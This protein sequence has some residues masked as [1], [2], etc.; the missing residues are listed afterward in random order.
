MSGEKAGAW[1][2]IAGSGAGLVIMALHPTHAGPPDGGHLDMVVVVHAAAI[3][4]APVLAFGAAMLTRHLGFARPLPVLGLIFY[5]FGVASVMLAAAMSGLVVPQIVA[6]GPIDLGDEADRL[7]NFIIYTHWLNQAFA[8]IHVALVSIAIL[9][10]SIAWPRGGVV[11]WFLRGLGLII[12]V[13]ILTWQ[14]SG[15]LHLN[16]LGMGH[17]VAVHGL[18]IVFAAVL[19]LRA[20]PKQA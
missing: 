10:W 19:M 15:H 20:Q 3:G 4:A 14:L 7:R 8:Q 1:A 12:G 2:L 9:L 5:L 11:S 16:V 17:V 18:W 13:G 6:E